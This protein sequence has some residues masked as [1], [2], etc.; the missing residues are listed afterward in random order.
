MNLSTVREEYRAAKA[1]QAV[2]LA[3]LDPVLDWLAQ[4]GPVECESDEEPRRSFSAWKDAEGALHFRADL[5]LSK[6]LK[7]ILVDDEGYFRVFNSLKASEY[8]KEVV[9][10]ILQQAHKDLDVYMEEK[11]ENTAVN[12]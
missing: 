8:S 11:I 6:Q 5:N 12:S 7:G 3:Q 2:C 4:N 9:F 1:T 10:Q